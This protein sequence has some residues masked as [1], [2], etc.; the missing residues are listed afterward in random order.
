MARTLARKPQEALSQR[1]ALRYHVTGMPWDETR[2]YV[3]HHLKV[4]G[5]DRLLF[6][7]GALKQLF[8]YSQ[9]LPRKINSLALRALETAFFRKHELVDETTMEIVAA[10]YS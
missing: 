5:V 7:E 1:I 8:Q 2:Q 4:T 10:E 6:T 9:G 3:N